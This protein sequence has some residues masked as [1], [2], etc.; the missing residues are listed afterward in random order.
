MSPNYGA[1]TNDDRYIFILNQDHQY[2]QNEEEIVDIFDALKK[3]LV[4]IHPYVIVIRRFLK[5]TNEKPIA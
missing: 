4:C 5:G 3:L 2:V 1:T